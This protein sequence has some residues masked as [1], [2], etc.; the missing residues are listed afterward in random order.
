MR[1]FKKVYEKDEKGITRDWGKYQEEDIDRIFNE[2]R[3]KVWEILPQ[4]K[5]LR[6]L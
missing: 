2:A 3:N 5:Q 4:F 6:L 1:F